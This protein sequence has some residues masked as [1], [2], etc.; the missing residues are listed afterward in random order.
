MQ[1]SEISIVQS[2]DVPVPTKEMSDCA[3]KLENPLGSVQRSLERFLSAL[4]AVAA[5]GAVVSVGWLAPNSSRKPF[6][7]TSGVMFVRPDISRHACST[8]ASSVS[9][10]V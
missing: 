10:S 2:K 9:L 5:E 6:S 7:L 3:T 1:S 8:I 4:K